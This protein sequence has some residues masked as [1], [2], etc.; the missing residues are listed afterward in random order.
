MKWPADKIVRWE[1]FFMARGIFAEYFWEYFSYEMCAHS[2]AY[3]INC[4]IGRRSILSAGWRS[5]L[6]ARANVNP[7][8]RS[9]ESWPSVGGY[10]FA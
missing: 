3:G 2:A 6:F 9:N 8:N 5:G 10:R 7:A 4:A 1:Y